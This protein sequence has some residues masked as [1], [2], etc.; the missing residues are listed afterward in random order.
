MVNVGLWITFLVFVAMCLFERY[1]N[2]PVKLPSSIYTDAENEF[3]HSLLISF[4]LFVYSWFI[5]MDRQNFII[6]IYLF[7]K[8]VQRPQ[9]L[10]YYTFEYI[11]W[12]YLDIAIILELPTLNAVTIFIGGLIITLYVSMY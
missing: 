12:R 8:Q 10:K 11:F 4:A 1:R 3:T 2:K 6:L 5:F 7:F 9:F